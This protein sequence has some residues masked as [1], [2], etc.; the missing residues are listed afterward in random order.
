MF[1]VGDK[2]FYNAHGVCIIED[3]QE[4]T[5]WGKK[6]PYYILRSYHN[7]A[8]KLYYPVETI[9][10]QLTPIASK[11]NAEMILEQFKSPPDPWNERMQDRHQNYHKILKTNNHIQIA[12][13]TNTILRKKLELENQ[14]KKLPSGD[15]QILNQVLPILYKELAVSFDVTVEEV[16]EIVDQLV[17]E[18]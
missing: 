10:S 14:D 18:H 7:A 2:V 5:F 13:M 1:T 4:K 16:T 12:K 3:I 15:H 9:Q 17:R 6:K 8:L 11:K